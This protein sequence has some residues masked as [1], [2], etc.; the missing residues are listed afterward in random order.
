MTTQKEQVGVD[1][2][3]D[4]KKVESE[5]KDQAKENVKN[6]EENTTA[7]GRKKYDGGPIPR[8]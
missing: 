4:A 5:L 6:R 3:F 1:P 8:P 7:D 2:D